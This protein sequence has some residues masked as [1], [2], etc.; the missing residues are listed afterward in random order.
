[1]L[2]RGQVRVY[3]AQGKMTGTV[4]AALPIF[5]GFI[6]FTLNKDYFQILFQHEYGLF[7]IG[8]A[9]LLEIVGYFWIR[10]IIHIKI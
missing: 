2:T 3:T 4:L 6:V 1:M 9:I 7:M 10:K 5:V 8:M